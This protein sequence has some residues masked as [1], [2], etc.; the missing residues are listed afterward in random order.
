[1]ADVISWKSFRQ[2][3]RTPRLKNKQL[4]ARLKHPMLVELTL[5]SG[6]DSFFLL[7]A[8]RFC[9]TTL[10]CATISLRSSSIFPGFISSVIVLLRVRVG[11]HPDGPAGVVTE[12]GLAVM[13][14]VAVV[15]VEVV[16]VEVEVVA[17]VVMV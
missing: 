16:A 14:V 7:K 11:S 17:V 5:G 3:K 9:F 2:S 1:M 13:A 15:E 12:L 6:A 8:D 4:K 10:R